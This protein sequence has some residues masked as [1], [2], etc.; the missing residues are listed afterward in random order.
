MDKQLEGQTEKE[1]ER[2]T[3]VVVHGLVDTQTETYR[4]IYMD[5]QPSDRP[6]AASDQSRRKEAVVLRAHLDAEEQGD[7]AVEDASDIGF[8]DV[9]LPTRC[10]SHRWRP[11]SRRVCGFMPM[12]L[13]LVYATTIQ[14]TEIGPRSKNTSPPV[15][16]VYLFI[17]MHT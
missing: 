13:C 17:L 5:K 4:E 7:S 1:T 14:A 8:C 15:G 10:R 6:T 3:D 2:Q 16:F 11:A 9:H 12:A